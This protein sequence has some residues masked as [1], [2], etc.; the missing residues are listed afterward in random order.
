MC[1]VLCLI[2]PTSGYY[3]K[4]K[5]N[6]DLPSHS[7][8]MIKNEKTWQTDYISSACRRNGKNSRVDQPR[9][10][11]E[12]ESSDRAALECY[13]E[14]RWHEM[15]QSE[16]SQII[17]DFLKWLEA[18]TKQGGATLQQCTKH[19]QVEITDM[20]AEEKGVQNTWKTAR[21]QDWYTRNEWGS[22][23]QTT[24]KIG[25]RERSHESSTQI[26]TRTHNLLKLSSYASMPR[27]GSTLHFRSGLRNCA[28]VAKHRDGC[29]A[30]VG[31]DSAIGITL[32]TII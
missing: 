8:T 12:L 10:I 6:L 9:Q 5:C 4:P 25:Y 11:R 23:S 2:C 1:L 26:H 19:I 16:R 3:G 18:K 22:K 31:S 14:R 29:A 32:I 17:K 21:K 13:L 15:P 7:Q 27:C 30:A 20:G 28:T 24:G